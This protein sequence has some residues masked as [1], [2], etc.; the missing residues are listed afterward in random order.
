MK[1]KQLKKGLVYLFLIVFGIF[2]VYPLVWLFFASFKTN[3][4]LFGTTKLLPES[5][6]MDGL[7][8]GWKSSGRFTYARF[9]LNTLLLDFL[10]TLSSPLKHH[11]CKRCLQLI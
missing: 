6:S 5:F 9:Y 7:I 3:A 2:M 11:R 1:K 4:E 8:N 10:Y